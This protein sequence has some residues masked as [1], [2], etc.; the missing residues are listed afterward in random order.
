MSAQ[1]YHPFDLGP[2][3]LG[4][5]RKFSSVMREI[6]NVCK[7]ASAFHVHLLKC[8]FEQNGIDHSDSEKED[9]E[10]MISEISP[11][12][13]LE[14]LLFG[15]EKAAQSFYDCAKSAL[16]ENYENSSGDPLVTFTLDSASD[17]HV[18]QLRS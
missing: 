6:K 11:T 13:A 16:L 1:H 2:T 7:R 12:P 3:A 14:P 10:S 4:H 15:T 8:Q 5:A 18:I 17:I 9:N